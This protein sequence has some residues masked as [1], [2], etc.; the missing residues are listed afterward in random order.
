MIKK[1]ARH[2][3]T[4]MIITAGAFTLFGGFNHVSAAVS[5]RVSQTNS[6]HSGHHINRPPQNN[7]YHAGNNANNEFDK[8]RVIRIARAK[9]AVNRAKWYANHA[10]SKQSIRR[11]N[12]NLV[13]AE[14]QLNNANRF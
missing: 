1:T 7:G 8:F 13:K 6:V 12:Q 5:N 9:R 4:G 3:V 11:A 2:L 14:Q 10:R